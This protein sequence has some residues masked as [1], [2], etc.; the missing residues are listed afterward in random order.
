MYNFD[1]I[2]DRH[3]TRCCNVDTLKETFGR[4]DLQS[5]WIADM[6]FRTP[7]FILNALRKRLDHPILGYPTTGS[8]YFEIVSAWVERL[9]G[10]KVPAG[11]FR[12]IPGIVKGL[13]F[14][15]RCLLS[16]GDKV[17]IQP[18]VYHPFRETTRACGFEVVCN[19]LKPVY[20]E[21]G[22]L[23]TYEMDLEGLESLIDSKTRMLILCN[24]HNPA[25]ICHPAATLRRLASICVRHGITVLSDEIHGEMALF[26]NEHL[27]FASVSDEAAACSISF[28]APSKT[29][30]IA[31][32]VSSY[33]IVRDPALREK[34]FSYLEAGEIDY[35]SIFSAEATRAAYTVEGMA[36]LREMLA[37]VEENVRFTDSWLREKLPVIRAVIP[38][39]S[40]M[41][42]LDCRKLELTQEQ[43][44]DLF[45]NKARLALNDGSM[46]GKEGSGFMRL[47]IGCPRS[48][49]QSALESLKTAVEQ[50]RA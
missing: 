14:A 36:W 23:K 34:F 46:F 29:F 40:F 38:E 8:D 25:G 17:I 41:V 35:P 24:P 28:L 45:V 44:V 42:W 48:K 10:W 12:Y 7:D 3:G 31:G 15:M 1:E 6:D 27:P 18:P 49:I 4:E 20:D 2:I 21:D 43:L 30:N 5:H 9:L 13:A 47:N 19:P 32:V 39:A 22:F 50:S 16:P 37:Y 33:C 11:E 26:G